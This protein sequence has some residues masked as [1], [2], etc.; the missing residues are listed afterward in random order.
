MLLVNSRLFLSGL[1]VACFY[2]TASA[3]TK[4]DYSQGPVLNSN[5]IIGMSGAFVSIAEGADAHL[6]NPA[7]FAMRAPHS[8]ND[9]FDWDWSLY[10]LSDAVS[11]DG[12]TPEAGA[13]AGF[14][15]S[16]D[17]FGLGIDARFGIVGFGLH[18]Y[19]KTYDVSL[20]TYSA[21]GR[22]LESN[23]RLNQTIFALGVGMAAP[24]FDMT[25]GL[26]LKGGNFGIEGSTAGTLLD[27]NGVGVSGGAVWHPRGK[28]YR[29]GMVVTSRVRVATVETLPPPEF[30]GLEV[31][32]MAVPG[33]ASFGGSW[34]FGERHYNP[35]QTWGMDAFTVS[36]ESHQRRR[37]YILASMDLVLDMPTD[38]T[39]SVASFLRGPAQ[40]SGRSLTAS[41]RAGVE[42]EFWP[43][44][45]RARSGVY[46]EPSR[47]ESAS[48]RVHFTAGADL[49][50]S[51]ITAWNLNFVVDLA[52]NYVNGG[53]GLSFWH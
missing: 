35:T 6:I 15:D 8:R 28:P 52:P 43:N 51:F 47:V 16:T 3:E 12:S 4:L 42:S 26:S 38:D 36:N 17:F 48:G 40:V 21:E 20:P 2:G 14:V 10:Y 27:L 49:R 50:V 31:Q 23:Y 45:M 33:R 9:F 19:S 39:I 18:A 1:L 24:W 13:P 46:Y 11:R 25:F 32:S 44:R 29:A 22:L 34:M 41:P 53:L 37:Q 5:R 7:S 30:S